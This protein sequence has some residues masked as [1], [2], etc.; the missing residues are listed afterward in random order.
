MVRQ[1]RVIISIKHCG[2]VVIAKEEMTSGTGSLAEVIVIQQ[3][4]KMILYILMRKC[5]M[6]SVIKIAFYY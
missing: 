2:R 6:H 3:M 1:A 5:T 4:N